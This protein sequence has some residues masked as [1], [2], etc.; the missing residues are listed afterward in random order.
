MRGM[1]Y[2]ECPVCLRKRYESVALDF[3]PCFK[4][5]IDY[6]IFFGNEFYGPHRSGYRRI[7]VL[8]DFRKLLTS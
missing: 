7:F 4:T 8:Q 6:P 2:K 1:A 3:L 5:T